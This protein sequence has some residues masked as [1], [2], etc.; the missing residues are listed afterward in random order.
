MYERGYRLVWLYEGGFRT[1]FYS[2][3]ANALFVHEAAGE[4]P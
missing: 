3:G 2:V 4:K 1:H